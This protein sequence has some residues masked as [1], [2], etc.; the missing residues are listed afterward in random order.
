M[1]ME[2]ICCADGWDEMKFAGWVGIVIIIVI[3]CAPAVLQS[4]DV[5]PKSLETTYDD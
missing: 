3:L 2:R 4:R 1:G 5:E